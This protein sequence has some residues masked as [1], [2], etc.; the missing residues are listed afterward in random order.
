MSSANL[1]NQIDPTVVFGFTN[2]PENRQREPLRIV[3]G[4]GVFI[5][6]ER[7]K[8]YIEGASSFYCTSLGFSEEE[9]IEAA[10]KQMRELPFYVTAAHRS[11]PVV[12]ELAERLAAMAPMKK[13]TPSVPRSVRVFPSRRFTWA[14]PLQAG[15]R[16]E[17]R[18]RSP[19]PH[20]AA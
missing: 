11:V 10:V 12:E 8:D 16:D 14:P 17:R 13:M 19:A 9:L 1:A 4:K 2:L 18:D 20:Q 7:G 15:F 5:Y 3:R 6:D